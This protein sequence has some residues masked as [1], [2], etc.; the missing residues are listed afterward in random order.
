M[1]KFFSSAHRPSAMSVSM[2]MRMSSPT[3]VDDTLHVQIPAA[4]LLVI[5]EIQTQVTLTGHLL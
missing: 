5:L 1:A 3:G 4:M 2:M